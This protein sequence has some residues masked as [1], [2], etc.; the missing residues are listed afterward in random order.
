MT[1]LNGVIAA[2]EAGK[3]AFAAF[4]P[5]TVDAAVAFSTAAYDGLVFEGEHQPWDGLALRDALQY[6][7][8]RR[9]IATAGSVA[10]AVTPFAR[11]PANGGELSQWHA[12]Q[13]L[14]LGCY[15]IVWPHVSTV[16]EAH[17]AV[18]ACR[19]PRLPGK[20]IYEPQGL[21][22]D[23]PAAAARYWGVTQPDYY[24][25]A[26]VWPLAPEGEILVVLQIE[27]TRGIANLPEML[28]EVPG[29]GAILIGEG[30]LSQDLGH[31]REYDH[32]LVREA[33]AHVVATCK[34]YNVP[35]GHPHVGMGNVER[36]LG[37]GFRFLM[38]TPTTTY[39]A[40]EKGM[41]LSGRAAAK[42]PPPPAGGADPY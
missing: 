13:A 31:P 11:I 3:P 42:A 9:Q 34:K 15:G 19:Y 32:P 5:M 27:D 25:R 20:P 41:E 1:R 35:V 29:I 12:K 26:D 7:M 40:L 38:C 17:N 10:P 16:E 37:E 21:R 18:A 2:L 23:G 8:N 30:D 4:A 22:G 39:P 14:D 24:R 36:V 33:M 28:R 6:L